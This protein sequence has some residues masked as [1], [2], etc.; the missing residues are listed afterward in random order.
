MSA[1]LLPARSRARAAFSAVVPGG[2]RAAL[3]PGPVR[4]DGSLSGTHRARA[5]AAPPRRR[6]RP[7]LGRLCERASPGPPTC[8]HL[9]RPLHASC[10]HLQPPARR[11]GGWP[12]D[13]ARQG[14]PARPS[15][16]S[17]DAGCRGMPAAV[18]A[19]R[20]TAWVPQE[21]P[22]GL[23]GPPRAPGTPGTVPHTARPRAAPLCPSRSRG[24][25]GACR[26][27]GGAREG[28]SGLP[29]RAEATEHTHVSTASG[30]GPVWARPWTGH[31]IEATDAAA[32]AGV[33]AS[34]PRPPGGAWGAH[35]GRPGVLTEA[36]E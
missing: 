34:R 22:L 1:A 3:W 14:L 17:P 4:L 28:R 31:V 23:P 15:P 8:P 2:A 6:A 35:H 7:G 11:P 16:A 24:P 26:R 21:A 20:P 27:G 32:S 29:A 5:L 33:P 9:P 10:G 12:G 36:L 30:V 18:H 19:A 25:P 13:L